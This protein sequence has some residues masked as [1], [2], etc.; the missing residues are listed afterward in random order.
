MISCWVMKRL[1][2]EPDRPPAQAFLR[3]TVVNL[4]QYRLLLVKGGLELHRLY[5][6][7]SR[8]VEPKIKGDA[9]DHVTR[10]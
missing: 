7:D 8:Q 6:S 2:M 3:L 4:L 1:G 9:P 10:L 5:F